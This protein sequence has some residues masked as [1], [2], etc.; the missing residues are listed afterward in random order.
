M[1]RERGEQWGLKPADAAGDR[2]AW[3]EL[4]VATIFRLSD[5]AQTQTGR[6]MLLDKF[7]VLLRGDPHEFGRRVHAQALRRGLAQAR[8]VYVVA[9]GA[10]WIWNIVN[11]RFSQ[12]EGL[13]DF[14]H[15]SQH[16]WSVAHALHGDGDQ[17][18]QWVEPLLHQLRHG[19]HGRVTDLLEAMAEESDRAA[20]QRQILRRE[21][22]YFDNH[23]DHMDYRK[24][25]DEGRPI[26]SGAVESSCKQIQGRF[27]Q[28]GQ[29][30]KLPTEKPLL[31]LKMAS[32]NKDWDEIWSVRW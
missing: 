6:P 4:K 20:D 26:G 2:V 9:D 28:T 32:Q 11:D 5:R 18:R 31:A 7:Q 15:A 17:E 25:A 10:V 29:F 3:H 1:V 22:G 21:A 23:R 14:Y 8:N 24:A 13:V 12:A 30:W 16:L 19:E 27:K